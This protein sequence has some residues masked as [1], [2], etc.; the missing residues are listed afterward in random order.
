M[1]KVWGRANSTNVK[2]VLWCLEEVGQPYE[3]VDVGGPF[4]GLDTAEFGALNPNRRIPVLEDSELVLW[5]SNSIVRYLAARYGAGPLLADPGRRAEADQ[6]MDWAS[7]N[8]VPQFTT[9][10]WNLVRTAPEKRDNGAVK[11]AL[12]AAG[13]LLTVPEG[14]LGSRPFLS[15]DELGIGDIPLGTMIHAWFNM[16]IDRPELPHLEA[17]YDRLLTR[18]AYRAVVALPLT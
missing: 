9:I 6:W 8:F 18:P 15:G 2:K 12:A 4:G 14:V 7:I 1:L 16:P 17:W 13:T 3:R 11:A 5:E 10:F